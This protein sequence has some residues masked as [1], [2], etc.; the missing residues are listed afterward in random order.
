MK[1]V[2]SSGHGSN[3]QGADGYLNEVDEARKVV[4]RVADEMRA[5]GNTVY[6]FH[7]DTSDTQD[8][9][10]KTIVNYHNSKERDLDVSVHF[11][12]YEPTSQPMGTECLYLSDSSL[13][14]EVADTIADAGGFKNRGAKQR[15][16]L[17]FL[18]QTDEPAILIEVCF[19]DSTVDAELYNT[20]FDEICARLAHTL[21]S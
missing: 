14:A 20:S 12:A 1:I 17:Y 18:N 6:T 11:N 2:I 7:D 13:A 15:S 10:L 16:D 9:N 8:E 4:D 21:E 5:S 3:V 19:V